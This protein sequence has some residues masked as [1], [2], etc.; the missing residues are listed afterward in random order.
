MI[1]KNKDN[2]LVSDSK[3]IKAGIRHE[4]DV[5][6]HLS[7]GFSESED[8][9]V[10]NDLTLSYGG[11]NAQ[12]DHLIVHVFGFIII[13]SKSIYG[14]INVN[15]LGEWSR[16]YQ[17]KWIGM[18]SPIKQAEA[19]MNILKPLLNEH[20]AS[21]LGKLLGLQARFGGRQWDILCAVSSSSIINRKNIPKEINE[22]IFKSEFINDKIKALTKKSSFSLTDS[23]PVFK[24]EELANICSFLTENGVP[25]QD[26]IPVQEAP[27]EKKSEG[28]TG[29]S[30]NLACKKCE[31][32]QNLTAAHGRYGYFLKC[33][34]GANTAMKTICS[35]CGSKNIK[36]RKSKNKYFSDCKDCHQSVLIF[37][38]ALD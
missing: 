15:D 7:R 25:I 30:V 19:Q 1:I 4:N 6:F 24:A 38:G 13:E 31:S 5:A 21:L 32:S 10:L 20:A 9:M 2:D 34:C 29:T 12:I 33:T 27:P 8:V 37:K 22:A 14:E 18:P 11:N 17:G 3:R 28:N 35:S 36:V 26:N 16:S 23:R